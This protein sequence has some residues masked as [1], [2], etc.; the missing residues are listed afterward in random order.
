[1]IGAR[2]RERLLTIRD[3]GLPHWGMLQRTAGMRHFPGLNRVAYGILGGLIPGSCPYWSKMSA[4]DHARARF[5]RDPR[6][7]RVTGHLLRLRLTDCGFSLSYCAPEA[8]SV[9]ENVRRKP[10]FVV[11]WAVHFVRR[12]T[13]RDST[14]RSRG[15]NDRGGPRSGTFGQRACAGDSA[16]WS[17]RR[18]RGCTQ[19]NM[20][21]SRKTLLAAHRCRPTLRT[22][23]SPFEPPSVRIRVHLCFNSF[24]LN[25]PTKTS[26]THNA[27]RVP[28]AIAPWLILLPLTP[29]HT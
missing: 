25:L 2:H 22:R 26:R 14:R 13:R 16:A 20:F 9:S 21:T 18:I 28:S 11:R 17:I 6:P 1:V 19:I 12:Y 5:W 15:T 10:A 8:A 4:S 24:W 3:P 29:R 27:G 7:P 23:S